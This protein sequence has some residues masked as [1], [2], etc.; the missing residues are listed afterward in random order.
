[1]TRLLLAIPGDLG[2]RTGGYAYGRRILR[3][4]ADLGAEIRH[5]AL[6]GAF[7]FPS[8]QSVDAAIAHINSVVRRGDVLLV[9]GLA[10]GALPV[11]AIKRLRAPVMALC[12]HPLCLETGLTAAQADALRR[13]ELEALAAAAHVIVTSPHTRNA[14]IRDFDLAAPKISV[15]LPGAARAPRAGGTGRPVSLLAVGALVPRKGYVHLVEALG[16]LSALD[17]RLDIVGSPDHAPDTARLL[18]ARVDEL[19]LAARINF[20]GACADARLQALFDRADVFV[21]PSLYEGYGMALAEALI[22]G[23]AIVAT[24]GGAVVDT[25]PDAACLRV[26]AGDVASLRAAL[27]RVVTET[28]LRQRLS[29]AAWRAGQDLPRWEDT[30]RRIIYAATRLGAAG[31]LL[32]RA[33]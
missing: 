29:D 9:D 7:P 22:R 13:S 4:A 8:P 6:P 19:G 25:V 24:G 14:L 12:H 28:T 3:A 10:Y 11:T 16:E 33:R 2:A 20:V 15:A 18:R 26:A 30:A 21:S 17:W 27:R 5:I 31:W 32:L 1:M 23:L